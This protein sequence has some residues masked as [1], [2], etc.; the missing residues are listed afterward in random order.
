MISDI[1]SIAV[2]L[3][4]GLASACAA[5]GVVELAHW[6][7]R[8]KVERWRDP[9]P[10]LFRL[11]L[12]TARK[13]ALWLTLST[14]HQTRL[15]QR[16]E[17]AGVGYAILPGELIALRV[18]TAVGAV[19]LTGG[20]LLSFSVAESHA[21]ALSS[22]TGALGA[23]YPDLW[24]F[25]QRKRRQ[26]SIER[27]FPGLLELL[28]LTVRAG[29][30]F[31]TALNQTGEHLPDGPLK[32]ECQRL[33][34]EIR[35]G[36]SRQDALAGLAARTQLSCVQSFVGAVIQADE[37]GAAISPVLADQA[38]QGRRERFAAAEKKANEA[39]VRMLL[40]LVALLFPVTFL[41]IGFPIALQFLD[42]G[43]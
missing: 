10:R 18:L 8:E 6:P 39:P 35:T 43:I 14:E 23:A 36:F 28:A 22:L 25:E 40:P 32:V 3:L 12:P 31:G 11:L 19:L 41:I 20:L 26:R 1:D 7:A 21:L 42:G 9:A 4:L 33:N 37:T 27:H 24:L 16:L 5:T 30:G 2:P 17:T 38:R 13:I 34:R 15:Q 29:M